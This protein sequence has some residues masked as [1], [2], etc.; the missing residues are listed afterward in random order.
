MPPRKRKTVR[1]IQAFLSEM[2]AVE[3]SPDLMSS[4]TDAVIAEATAWQQ[5]PLESMDPVVF[6]DAVRVKI[7]EE[8]PCGA[9]PCISRDVFACDSWGRRFPPVV[10]SWRRAWP[11]VIPFFAFPPAVRRVIYTTNA[12]ERVHAR[13]RHISKTRGHLPTDEA[14]TKLIWLARRK[15][16]ARWGEK[17]GTHW[18][19]ARQPFAILFEDRFTHP[20]S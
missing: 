8:R 12:L 5:R 13:V 16:T 15:I 20:A 17:A 2:D 11:Q 14:A 19:L 3:G 9:R 1:E 4:V 18:A 10:A 7:R 6:F